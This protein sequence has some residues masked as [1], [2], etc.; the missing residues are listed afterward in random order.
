MSIDFPT[1]AMLY[2]LEAM[3]E[4]NPFTEE[5]RNKLISIMDGVAELKPIKNPLQAARTIHKYKSLEQ[6]FISKFDEWGGN[7]ER[8]NKSLRAYEDSNIPLIN[9]FKEKFTQLKKRF[10]IK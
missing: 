6:Q 5:Q 2:K 8:L 7:S 1:I 3:Q 4:D 10:N 9:E